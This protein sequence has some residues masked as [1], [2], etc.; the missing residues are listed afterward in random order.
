MRRRRF[1]P[2]NPDARLQHFLES[3]ALRRT[4]ILARA[5]MEAQACLA[6]DQCDEQLAYLFS[7]DSYFS[8]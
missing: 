4:A 1:L 3:E 7:E 5:R 6:A 8:H 2:L